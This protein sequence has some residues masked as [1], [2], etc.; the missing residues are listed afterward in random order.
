MTR[1]AK[2]HR[3][4]AG[5]DGALFYDVHVE[6]DAEHELIAINDLVPALVADGPELSRDILFGADAL[7]A[8]E[9]LF[10]EH[11]LD[12]WTDGRSSL[13]RPLPSLA[14]AS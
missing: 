13:H 12:A 5:E 14:L 3:R 7:L 1:Y 2:A 9:R 6:A 10:A 11:V 4:V 8:L